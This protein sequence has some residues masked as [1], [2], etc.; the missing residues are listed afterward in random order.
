MPKW[1]KENQLCVAWVET[2]AVGEK[3]SEYLVGKRSL[4]HYER[5]LG[6]RSIAGTYEGL[7]SLF[8]VTETCLSGPR[9]LGGKLRAKWSSTYTHTHTH[10]C[11]RARGFPLPPLLQ[12]FSREKIHFHYSA[13]LSSS[14]SAPPPPVLLNKVSVL[15]A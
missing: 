7:V 8:Q 1:P 2:E 13:I 3:R 5:L 9:R 12:P 15:R 11:T 14:L 4:K 10:A 6:S